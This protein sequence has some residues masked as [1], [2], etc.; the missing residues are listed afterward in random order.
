[1]DECDGEECDGQCLE[2]LLEEAK[3]KACDFELLA[4]HVWPLIVRPV[5]G[6]A[7]G[8]VE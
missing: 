4:A 8:D 7:S 3:R 6:G 5:H 1:M 2:C